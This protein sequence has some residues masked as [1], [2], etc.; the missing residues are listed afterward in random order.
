M[1]LSISRICSRSEG[2]SYEYKYNFRA[3]H[4]LIFIC[5]NY[6]HLI[7]F[8]R[9]VDISVPQVIPCHASR[10]NHWP[11]ARPVRRLTGW[12][13]PPR[14]PA[15]QRPPRQIRRWRRAAERICRR[16]MARTPNHHVPRCAPG[17]SQE[18]LEKLKLDD[19]KSGRYPKNIRPQSTQQAQ[20]NS[21]NSNLCLIMQ[22]WLVMPSSPCIPCMSACEFRFQLHKKDDEMK[23]LLLSWN[24]PSPPAS[25]SP[26][27]PCR[28][29]PVAAQVEVLQH[30]APPGYPAWPRWQILHSTN[31][32]QQGDAKNQSTN[33]RLT[34]TLVT[35]LCTNNQNC[36][37]VVWETGKPSALASG[38]DLTKR[39][40]DVVSACG[41]PPFAMLMENAYIHPN[42]HDHTCSEQINHGCFIMIIYP[43]IHVLLPGSQGRTSLSSTTYAAAWRTAGHLKIMRV[44]ELS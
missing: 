2:T 1:D 12:C 4:C 7:F 30:A 23:H 24:A 6:R 13:C 17:T 14:G 44:W 10:P 19:T 22:P 40:N 36:S 37:L 34:H 11:A 8:F 20:G 18:R 3:D 9:W 29:S 16:G 42:I 38:A 28:F 33:L 43:D 31:I 27:A 26:P 25:H 41:A 21:R 39:S 32:Y 15:P 35:N 5:L